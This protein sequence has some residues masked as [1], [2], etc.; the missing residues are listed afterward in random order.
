MTTKRNHADPWPPG[1]IGYMLEQEQQ[2]V[3]RRLLTAAAEEEGR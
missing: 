3:A 1:S 2:R